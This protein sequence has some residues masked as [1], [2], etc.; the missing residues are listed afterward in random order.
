MLRLTEKGLFTEGMSIASAFA[1]F[2]FSTGLGLKNDGVN[3]QRNLMTLDVLTNPL[4]NDTLVVGTKT[5]TFKAT[6]AATDQIKIG[7]LVTNGDFEAAGANWATQ[8]GWAYNGTTTKGL[9]HTAGLTPA[10]NLLPAYQVWVPGVVAGRTYT[11]VFTVT[12]RS[13]GSVTMSIG[14]VNGTV[15]ST[16]ATFTESLVATGDGYLSF[17]PTYDF[18]GK[19]SA[20]SVTDGV[21]NYKL[22]TVQGIINA[23]NV[24]RVACGVTAYQLNL[25]TKI[26]LV[27]EIVDATP[28]VTPDGVRIV[29]DLAWD[30]VISESVIENVNYFKVDITTAEEAK[31]TVLVERNAGTDQNFL[32]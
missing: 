24:N 12:E 22:E 30:T 19:I 8:T 21:T 10:D 20:V 4:A 9:K 15:R 25:A 11:V 27:A 28:T 26:A 31:P 5:F 32:Y 17:T 2:H 7:A 14:G 13:A 3:L 16:N 18:D 6:V 1:G 29:Q 23:I